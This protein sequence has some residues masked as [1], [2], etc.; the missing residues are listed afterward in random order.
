MNGVILLK[1]D[2]KSKNF[3][4]SLSILIVACLSIC[5][6]FLA[7]NITY[8]N[9]FI[10]NLFNIVSPF[11]YGLVLAYLLNRPMQ[12]IENFLENNLYKNRLKKSIKRIISVI[13]IFVLTALI[14]FLIGSFVIPQ[15]AQSISI[16]ASN[17][18]GYITSLQNMAIDLIYKFDLDKEVANSIYNLFSKWENLSTHLATILAQIVS[19]LLNLS[20]NIT[21]RIFN[22]LLS[23][24]V[25]IY[26]LSG[27]EKLMLQFKKLMFAIFP[28]RFVDK[29]Y[30][31]LYIINDTFG[32]YI[33]G[34]MVDAVVVGSLCAFLMIIFRF[35]FALLVGV[36]VCL[37]NVIPMIG[38]FIGAIPSTFIILM[39]NPVKAFWFVILIF[40]IQQIDGNILVPRIVGDSTGLSGL[41]VLFA[42]MVGG[43]L[44]GILGV[45][46]C[47]PTLSVI[48]KLL[49]IFINR[50]I[51][52]KSV[53]L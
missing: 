2:F 34:Q 1:I 18:P 52:E 23:I 14:I 48:F 31:V 26:V 10:R 13:I 19:Q 24:V 39:V 43:G 28:N 36:I 5:F 35:P 4:N 29:L 16:L 41:W 6:F 42:I 8:I 9:N 15:V 51:A 12:A 53:E 25:S 17:I 32:Q 37:T 44:F 45:L 3:V 20:V 40:I 21:S 46:L 11:V 38:P 22:I 49:R 47:V 33:S 50:R 7:K 30:S 27:K